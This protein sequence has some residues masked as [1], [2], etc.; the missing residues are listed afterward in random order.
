MSRERVAIRP[1][2]GDPDRRTAILERA[3]RRGFRR[4]VLPSHPP[5]VAAPGETI[6]LEHEGR[7][8]VGEPGPELPICR[9][10][11]EEELAREV[12]RTPSGGTL[13]IEWTA[14]RVIPLEN[15]IAARGHR[16]S[17]W[18]VAR[19]PSEVPGALG[20]LEHGA[21]LVIV[22]LRGP[23]EVDALEALVEGPLPS[24]LA[25]VDLP[26]VHLGPAGLGDR[27][28]VDTTSL[29]RPEEGLLVG[30]AAGFLFLV[31]SE[32]LGSKFSRPRPFRVNA[33]AAHSYVLLAD[34]ST[35]YLSELAPGDAVLVTQPGGGARSVRVGR[36]K[37]ERRPM[38]VITVDDNGLA[39]TVFLQEA[40]S[41]RL[42]TE[43]GPRTTTDLAVGPK[44]HG[45]RLPPARH[46]GRTVEETIEER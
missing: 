15:A 21:D 1:R 10:D 3:R 26:I 36:I 25:W 40:E 7:L 37:I 41:V 13:V 19:S 18:V 33:G 38:V 2:S 45:V 29:L 23:E 35:R 27:V 4:F 6:F 8:E 22:D 14:D 12:E 28:I 46:L 11:S 32:A 31:T 43:N 17:L 30:S 9:I 42:S 34:G 16:F 20:A 39:R 24:H 5:P 44:V